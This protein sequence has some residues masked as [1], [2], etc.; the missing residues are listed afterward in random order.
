MIETKKLN[1]Y[2]AMVLFDWKNEEVIV[3]FTSPNKPD[4]KGKIIEVDVWAGNFILE[5]ETEK[6]WIQGGVRCVR[7]IK[8]DI[9]ESIPEALPVTTRKQYKGIPEA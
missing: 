8:T 6:V 1:P 4:I 9:V 5:T 7:Q 3:E 2:Q